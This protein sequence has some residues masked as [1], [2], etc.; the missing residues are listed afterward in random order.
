MFTSILVTTDKPALADASVLTAMQ[1]ARHAAIQHSD[2][3]RTL[4]AS[5]RKKNNCLHAKQRSE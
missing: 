3:G 2:T 4:N 1:T 5:I